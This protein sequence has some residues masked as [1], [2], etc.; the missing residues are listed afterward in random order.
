MRDDGKSI[1]EKTGEKAGGNEISGLRVMPLQNED[2]DDVL[3]IENV[4]YP[5]PWS[6]NIFEKELLNPVSHSF[7]L[8]ADVG[9]DAVLAA[10]IFLWIVHGEGH[11]LNLTV[12]P[13]LR[14][15][16]LARELLAFTLNFMAEDGVADC[17]LE[18]RRSNSAARALYESFGF[19]EFYVRKNYYGTEDALVMGLTITDRDY[20]R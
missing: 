2:L 3:A 9:A 7:A 4:S 11:I 13:E 12:K 19:R 5:N 6:R 17:F 15:R 10:Y 16:G 18:V 1:H 20:S 8:K 14:G